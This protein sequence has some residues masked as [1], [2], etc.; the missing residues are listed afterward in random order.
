MPHHASKQ[1][2]LIPT[3]QQFETSSKSWRFK[4]TLFAAQP[5]G[6]GLVGQPSPAVQVWHLRDLTRLGSF[7]LIVTSTSDANDSV[8]SQDQMAWAQIWNGG[9]RYPRRETRTLEHIQEQPDVHAER[10]FCCKDSRRR[11]LRRP[12]ETL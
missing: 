7:S 3:S 12:W 9:Y 6:C 10:S 8:W 1:L 11:H 2:M 5:L 4:K